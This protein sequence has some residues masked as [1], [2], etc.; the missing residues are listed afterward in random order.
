ML[1]LTNSPILLAILSFGAGALVSGGVVYSQFNSQTAQSKTETQ[2]TITALELQLVEAKSEVEQLH[3]KSESVRLKEE[4]L[5]ASIEGYETESKRLKTTNAELS[6]QL[7]SSDELNTQQKQLLNRLNTQLS[8]LQAK[9]DEQH[10]VLEK[11]KTFFLTQFKLQQEIAQLNKERAKL[12]S[13]LNKLV[14]ECQVYLDGTSWD[15][16]SDACD[17]KEVAS[18]R[19]KTIDETINSKQDQV[20]EIDL[21]SEQL[22]LQ[23]R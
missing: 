22:G 8:E 9:S 23:S 4:K 21:V 13:T 14:S 6:K 7:Q 2:E 16:K 20:V 3:L 18:K 5:S 15:A 17:R 19:L 12:V 10:Q 1:G 11:A